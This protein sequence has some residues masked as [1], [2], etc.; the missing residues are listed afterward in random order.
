MRTLHAATRPLQGEG[1]TMTT[2]SADLV[3]AVGS[4]EQGTLLQRRAATPLHELVEAAL[5]HLA[6]MI[7][8]RRLRVVSWAVARDRVRVRP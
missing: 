6:P 4:V 2:H 7:A 8:R 1:Q 3:E 5:R